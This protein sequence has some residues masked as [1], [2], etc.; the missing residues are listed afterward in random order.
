MILPPSILGSGN[1][2]NKRVLEFSIKYTWGLDRVQL[3]EIVS[4]QAKEL[5]ITYLCLTYSDHVQCL[6]QF[7][8]MA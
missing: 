3:Q 8:Q 1:P 6:S 2:I 5:H 7:F 4:N